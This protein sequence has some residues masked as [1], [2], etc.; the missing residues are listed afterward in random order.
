[1]TSGERVQLAAAL[2]IDVDDLNLVDM[3]DSGSPLGLGYLGE[4]TSII[5]VEQQ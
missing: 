4:G 2:K 1:M 5:N 3:S